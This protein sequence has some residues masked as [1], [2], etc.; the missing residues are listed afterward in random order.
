MKTPDA[1]PNAPEGIPKWQGES[2]NGRTLLV[3]CEQGLGATIQFIRYALQ[4]AETAGS[5]VIECQ[6]PL[7]RLFQSLQCKFNLLPAGAP[8]AEADYWIPLMSIPHAVATT[9]E[10]IPGYVP[11]L[12]AEERKIAELRK[13]LLHFSRPRI[14]IAWQGNPPFGRDRFPSISPA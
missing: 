3:R 9:V 8:L 10:S 12:R 6:P 11:Y 5:L 7:L 2:L 4:L 14:G 13:H 1:K